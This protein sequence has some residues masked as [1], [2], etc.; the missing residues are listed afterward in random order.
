MQALSRITF[1]PYALAFT[2]PLEMVLSAGTNKISKYVTFPP[3]VV[4]LN[5]PLQGVNGQGVSQTSYHISV[6]VRPASAAEN[7]S[8]RRTSYVKDGN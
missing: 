5:A 2:F 8:P 4:T 3:L 7:R 1:V 6:S